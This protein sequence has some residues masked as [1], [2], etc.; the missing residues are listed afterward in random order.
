MPCIFKDKSSDN[1]ES[2]TSNVRR[3]D[4]ILGQMSKDR[5]TAQVNF[6][7]SEDDRCL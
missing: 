4:Y 2:Q 1:G 6:K 5:I 7:M 3:L